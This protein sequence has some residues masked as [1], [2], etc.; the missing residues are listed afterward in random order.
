MPQCFEAVLRVLQ[1]FR[2][3][4]DDIADWSKKVRP[5]GIIAGHD[6]WNSAEGFGALHTNLGRAI[7]HLTPAEKVTVCQAKD[8]ALA[9]TQTNRIAPWFVTGE[10]DYPSFFWVKPA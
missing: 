7:T 6:Y 5:G 2:A 8:A 1:D 9:W 3:V 4:I 10:K